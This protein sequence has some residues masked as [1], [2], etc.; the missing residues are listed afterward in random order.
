MLCALHRP[1]FCSTEN[2]NAKLDNVENAPKEDA[3][4][5]AENVE[6]DDIDANEE[7]ID[8]AMEDVEVEN[9]H[10]TMEKEY[11]EAEEENEY[12]DNEG[13]KGEEEAEEVFDEV[14]VQSLKAID[15]F[16]AMNLPF[17]KLDQTTF[18]FMS[19][20]GEV[21][22]SQS[23]GF[24][25]FSDYTTSIIDAPVF[26]QQANLSLLFFMNNRWYFGI[27]Y[28]DKTLDSSIYAG[29][30]DIE[31]PIKKH[32]RI[33]N[34]AINFPAIYPFIKGGA[35]SHLAPGAFCNI[36][37]DNWKFDAIIRY[38]SKKKYSRTFYG[39]RERV[40]E[41][42]SISNWQRARYFYIPSNNLAFDL[43]SRPINV[44]VKDSLM[45]E[46]RLLAKNEYKLDSKKK[47][48]ILKKS[49]IYGVAINI[50]DPGIV[51]DTIDKTKIYFSST[52][53][54]GK[55]D[56]DVYTEIMGI[57]FLCLKK[58]NSF[59]SFE[60]SSIYHFDSQEN[61]REV[62]VFDKEKEALSGDF[63]IK[64]GHLDPFF[65]DS[66]TFIEGEVLPSHSTTALYA[67]PLYR[68][69]FGDVSSY[70]Y[71]GMREKEDENVKNTFE[72]LSYLYVPISDYILPNNANEDDIEVYKN[73]LPI[74]NF[75]YDSKSHTVHI[76][77]VSSSD[78]IE[79]FWSENR[80]YSDEGAL[81]IA[82]GAQ[83][84]ILDMIT[85][86]FAT[87]SDVDIKKNNNDL[88]D[89]Y[90]LSSGIDFLYNDF[91]A[92]S[93]FGFEAMVFKRREASF[94]Y[95][96]HFYS[97]YERDRE[98]SIFKNI[99]LLADL[100]I[101]KKEYLSLHSNMKTSFEMW[102][103]GLNAHLSLQDK[104]NHKNV[105]ESAGHGIS[106][107]LWFFYM[108]ESFFI[109]YNTSFISRT[110][111]IKNT[112]YINLEHASLISYDASSLEQSITSSVGPMIPTTNV[113][114]FFLELTLKM[115]QKYKDKT[116]SHFID[117]GSYWEIW[118]MSLRDSYSYGVGKPILRGE[119]LGFI[120]NWMKVREMNYT[121][122]FNV[123]GVNFETKI[124][125]EDGEAFPKKNNFFLSLDFTLAYNEVFIRPFWKREASK[126]FA[127]KGISSYKDD[128]KSMFISL[129]EQYWIFASPVFYDIFD[130]SLL[131][132]LQNN[133]L[134]IYTY[135]ATYGLNVSRVLSYTKKDIYTPVEFNSSFSRFIK[136]DNDRDKAAEYYK[137][138]L[139]IKYAS[140]DVFATYYGKAPLKNITK[141]T[142]F[143]AYN[144]Y[145]LFSQK[146]VFGLGGGAEHKL[147]F[148]N[149]DENKSGIENK[150]NISLEKPVDRWRF[151]AWSEEVSFL[152]SYRGSAS[153][154]NMIFSHLS[155]F[156]LIDEREEKI[157]FS[158]FNETYSKRVGYKVSFS[159]SQKTKIGDNGELK[160]FCG[161]S[162]F[163]TPKPSTKLMFDFGISGKVEY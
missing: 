86:F 139:E 153:L 150:L 155:N 97:K 103:L 158:F 162:V 141:D 131:S 99:T 115:S 105:V 152:Y 31:S 1:S 72:L 161:L 21:I 6:R 70:I 28:R 93:Y 34:K 132:K 68:Y 104:K 143:R 146:E 37:G 23:I 102:K 29:Y 33:G 64:M 44:Y 113:G 38:D 123:Q 15:N 78:K 20:F 119:S 116:Y 13:E 108:E 126:Q 32:I 144:L 145:M 11:A 67:E 48:L 109:N 140:E 47:L 66:A 24:E 84:K 27:N 107:P 154:F 17:I 81:R 65:Y 91:S 8:D 12:V 7:D 74:S 137:T 42:L 56:D 96:N 147:Y 77:G 14:L 148:Y 89:R 106:I 160:L 39:K 122:G 52:S 87:S 100:D 110:N 46:W 121:S 43:S 71:H 3:N 61:D 26:K 127:D 125:A 2:Q 5:G 54:D 136:S 124:F 82:L 151:K 117:R 49:F 58:Y 98:I 142:L 10:N 120:F 35:S 157:S 22:L 25:F 41:R 83:Y 130:I 88:V 63:H 9:V 135:I 114:N 94:S 80:Q 51:S 95:K 19:G 90:N 55:I 111:M 112:R 76:E 62:Y 59:S 85:L 60:V 129:K 18:L 156:H 75:T 16:D 101:D 134:D 118:E 30:I 133:A 138:N 159:H 50:F 4:A 57:P 36:E 40:E 92:G 163:S 53:L 69:P 79:I 128:F 149:Q 73:G 45:A